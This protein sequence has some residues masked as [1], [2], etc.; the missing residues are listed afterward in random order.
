M[1][2]LH[3]PTDNFSCCHWLWHLGFAKS[4]LLLLMLKV[5]GCLLWNSHLSTSFRCTLAEI[6]VLLKRY[7]L[8]KSVYLKDS[9]LSALPTFSWCFNYKFK[10]RLD[11]EHSMSLISFLSYTTVKHLQ[12]GIPDRCQII[13]YYALTHSRRSQSIMGL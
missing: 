12:S 10:S 11:C 3:N 5:S 6:A 2:S 9:P 7:C 8:C 4:F 13:F 1:S